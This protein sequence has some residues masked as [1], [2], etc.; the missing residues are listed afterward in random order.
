M[1]RIERITERSVAKEMSEMNVCPQGIIYILLWLG[2][3]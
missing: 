2:L 1:H 3:V